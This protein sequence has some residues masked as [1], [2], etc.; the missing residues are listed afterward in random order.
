[1]IVAHARSSS[2]FRT[3]TC[4][5]RANCIFVGSVARC[6]GSAEYSTRATAGARRQLRVACLHVRAGR[7]HA[8]SWCMQRASHSRLLHDFT[9]RSDSRLCDSS[10][11]IRIVCSDSCTRQHAACNRPPC[12]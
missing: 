3:P 5:S 4:K 6:L 12:S 2:A 9:C 10:S 7:V 11:L 1:L 8:V